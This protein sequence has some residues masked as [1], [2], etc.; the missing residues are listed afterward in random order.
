MV[1]ALVVQTGARPPGSA[2]LRPAVAEVD[3]VVA[4]G[5][6]AGLNAAAQLARRGL[7][8]VLVERR[9]V[10][11]GGARWRNGVLSWQFAR[12][13]V[14]RPL[15]V[16]R[17]EG[18]TTHLFDPDGDRAVKI[19][20]SPVIDADMRV[21]N[22]RLV[23][24]CVAAGVEIVDRVTEVAP[25]TAD[26]RVRGVRVVRDHGGAPTRLDSA[27]VVDAAGRHAPIAASSGLLAAGRGLRPDE[28]CSAAQYTHEVADPHGAATFLERHGARSGDTVTRLGAHG[29][30]SALSVSVDADLSRVSILTGTLATGQWGTGRDLLEGFLAGAGWVGGAEFGGEGL[31]PLRRPRDRCTAPGLALVGDAACQVFPA[32]GS[33]IGVGLMAGTLLAE[34]VAGA[35]DPGDEQALWGYQVAFQREVGATLAAFD[36]MRRFNSTIG[37]DGVRALFRSGLFTERVARSGLDQ[38]WEVPPPAES[39]RSLRVMAAEPAVG[40]PMARA[41]AS[42]AAVRSWYRRFPRRP[43]PRRLRP[44]ASV[45]AALSGAPD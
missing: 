23:E 42:A 12:A 21:L 14:S 34:S 24:D 19:S 20:D 8:V 37:T 3:V 5:G 18:A 1:G 29:G 6:T 25:L 10:G 7:S 9:P 45:A 44:W 26:G 33:G 38:R 39:V 22:Q 32:H 4:G 16:E 40:V 41:L 36:V 31:I 30:F 15:P 35:A 13:G 27:L 28:L 11:T 2:D 43:D 17:V